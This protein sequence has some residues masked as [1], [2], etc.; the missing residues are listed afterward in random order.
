MKNKKKI[1][2]IISSFVFIA[3]ICAVYFI[4]VGRVPKSDFQQFGVTF[5]KIHAEGLN[6]EWKQAY[7][8]IFD[9]LGI[10]KIRI[11]V[12]WQE[13]EPEEGE[14]SAGGG[15]TSGWD[16]SSI[17]FM[18]D[19]ADT[20]GGEIILVVGN[21]VPR[22]PECHQPEWIKENN[23][24]EFKNQKLLEYIEETIKRYND[25]PSLKYFQI[26][27]EPFLNFGICPDYN[28]YFIDEEIKLF[29]SLM[30]F[31]RFLQA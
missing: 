8:A 14:F 20:K 12:Y 11:P 23:N 29:P 17:D 10:K 5:S 27:N 3:T 7:Q 6:L 24:L 18:M 9:D 2:I 21:K 25:R 15:P 13:V 4:M 1:S 28:P 26:E 30:V 31:L 16:F 19:I 22:W